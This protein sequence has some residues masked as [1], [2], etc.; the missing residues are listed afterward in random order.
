MFNELN[1]TASLFITK[2]ETTEKYFERLFEIYTLKEAY[3]KMKG[4]NLNNIK[5]VEFII[6]NNE[7]ICSDHQVK[8]NIK[9]FIQVLFSEI[10]N[11]S[12]KDYISNRVLEITCGEAPYL[13]SR[14]DTVTGKMI[15]IEKAEQEF[16][17]Y[18]SKS[19]KII[20]I[21]DSGAIFIV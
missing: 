12:W 7:I 14:Y 1:Y 3:F 4:E 9:K 5:N 20:T 15:D 16:K 6:N 10:K 19:R 2:D 13:V 17:R 8:V 21:H 18:S 11:K